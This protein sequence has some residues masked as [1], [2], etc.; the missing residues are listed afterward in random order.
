MSL[1]ETI[2]EPMSNVNQAQRQFFDVTS[3]RSNSISS[4]LARV[5]N[6]PMV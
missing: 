6:R 1:L 4:V 3:T 5:V 2:L